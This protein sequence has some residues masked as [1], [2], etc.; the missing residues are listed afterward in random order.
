MRNPVA[1]RVALT[2]MLFA[3]ALVLGFFES[4]LTPVLGLPPGVKLGLANIV[5]MYALYF[6]SRREA[7]LLVALKAGFSLLVRGATAGALSLCGGLFSLV[8]MALL[9]LPKK[10]PS[11]LVVSISGALAHNLGQFLMAWLLLGPSLFV[12]LPVLL[13]SGI[14]MGIL[15]AALL[16]V[17]L[18]A[19]QKAGLAKK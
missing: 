1:R 9:L 16:R 14:V 2:G 3:L 6:L 17:L 7:L 12:Y 19:L 4:M 8:V 5:V 10:T 15:T 11:V 13:V 18:P